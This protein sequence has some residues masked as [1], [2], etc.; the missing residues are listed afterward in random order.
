MQALQLAARTGM[1]LARTPMYELHVELD[2]RLVPFAGYTM[3]LNYPAGILTE[4]R[5]TRTQASLFDVSHM[6]RLRVS[7]AHAAAAL[8]SLCPTDL[9][10]LPPG[11]LR[12]SVFTNDDGG[13]V[14]D[15]ILRRSDN[16]FEI[17]ANAANRKID[18]IWLE[19]RIGDQCQ[20]RV[21]EDFALLALQGPRAAE[22]LAALQSDIHKLTFMR[23]AA[24]ELAGKPC[25]LGRC[26]YTGEDGFEI[27]VPAE[28][29]ITLAHELLAHE[30]VAPA[31]LGCRDSLRLE[32][33]L[34]LHGQDMD[35]T[36]SPVEAGLAWSIPRVRR[37]AG[38]RAGGFP[39]SQR[40]FAELE[41]GPA[42]QLTGLLPEG[43]APLR[44]E[45][46]LYDDDGN[47]VGIVTSGAH[48]PVREQPVALGY[49]RTTTLAADS[50]LHANL[51]NRLVRVE[52]TALPFVPHRYVR[53]KITPME[54]L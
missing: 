53:E 9:I 26:G 35:P 45:T 47:D 23:A 30:A 7:G 40:I 3:P 48:S 1:E 17:I 52:T 22:V 41:A 8:E 27:G 4:H 6:S 14:D 2:A 25:L 10:N 32:A 34:N 49:V 19:D 36:T 43:R 28:H 15:L 54:S 39:G 5:H 51:R 12:Y 29:A 31:G 16:D 11:V 21:N 37:A 38:E 13:I 20:I 18:L 46:V 44:H 33:G 24:L 42:R 50:R